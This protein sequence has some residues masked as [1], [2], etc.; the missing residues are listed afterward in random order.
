MEP[1]K[2]YRILRLAVSGFMRLKALDITPD[3]HVNIIKG[4]NRQGK[5]SALASIRAAIGGA[6]C[7][8]AKPVH[9]GADKAEIL[10]VLG[11]DKPELLVKRVIMEGGKTALEITSAD[12][13]KAPTPQT[14]LDGLYGK[15]AFDPQRF[16]LLDNKQQLEMLRELVGLDFSDLDR[17]RKVAYDERTTVNRDVKRLQ[18]QANGI[19]VPA[20]TPTEPISVMDLMMEQKRRDSHNKANQ[21]ERDKVEKLHQ[22]HLQTL[23]REAEIESDIASLEQQLANKREELSQAESEMEQAKLLLDAQKSTAAVLEDHDVEEIQTKIIEAQA[24]NASVEAR[25]RKQSVLVEAQEA[26]KKA[27]SLTDHLEA[28]DATKKGKLDAVE[29]PVEGLSFGDDGVIYKG[30]PFSQASDAEQM[31]VSFAMSAAMSPRLRVAL[32]RNAS[33][34][35]EEHKQ[36]IY[37]MAQE[38]DMQVF[39]EVVGT[40]GGPATV[41]IED[42]EVVESVSQTELNFSEG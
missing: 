8:P 13:Y 6:R 3:R 2:Q 23:N 22:D 35:D 41:L 14:I 40:E 7:F 10:C 18:A 27:K 9:Q 26:E 38:M 16:L 30:V 29:W 5:S 11:D 42:G 12:G 20:D 36:T 33:L 21:V 34:M 32:L 25:K 37:R 24:V 19:E 39:E 31:E 15:L 17:E 28:I 4:R 1:D